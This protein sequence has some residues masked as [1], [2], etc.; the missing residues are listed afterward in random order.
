MFLVVDLETT[1]HAEFLG[2]WMTYSH[3]KFHS[4]DSFHSLVV[5]PIANRSSHAAVIL[6]SYILQEE[7]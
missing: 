5:K 6:L 7:E 4:H 2:I 3:I 1:F